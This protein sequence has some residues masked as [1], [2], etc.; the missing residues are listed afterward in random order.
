MR[1]QLSIP[2]PGMKI[3]DVFRFFGNIIELF[4]VDVC[5]WCSIIAAFFYFS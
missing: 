4:I 5:T 1:W 2:C 3:I